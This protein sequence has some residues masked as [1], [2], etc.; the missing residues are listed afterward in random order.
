MTKT[1]MLAGLAA[2]VLAGC[3]PPRYTFE[4]PPS[5]LRL[6]SATRS[7]LVRD[8]SLPEYASAIEVAVAT[9]DGAVKNAGSALWAD[10]PTRGVSV[11]LARQLDMILS[12]TVSSEPWPLGGLAETEVSVR[13]S[14]ALGGADGIYRLEGQYYIYSER[15]TGQSDRFAIAEPMGGTDAGDIA[16]AQSRAIGALA[17]QIARRLG[18]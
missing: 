8:V 5:G 15:G 17:E 1:L 9:G 13:M 12:A 16:A 11:A 10:Q 14:K 6:T 3:N 7:V 18:R 2:L 4:P